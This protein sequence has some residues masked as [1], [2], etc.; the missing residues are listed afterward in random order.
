MDTYEPIAQL[1]RGRLQECGTER[2][3]DLCSGAGGP[4]PSLVRHFRVAWRESTRSFPDC[5]ISEHEKTSLTFGNILCRSSVYMNAGEH[6]AFE[7]AIHNESE[8]FDG[9]HHPGELES[10]RY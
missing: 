5:Q 1:L 9:E 10:R 4:G 3:L 2:V 8:A 7:K 6:G